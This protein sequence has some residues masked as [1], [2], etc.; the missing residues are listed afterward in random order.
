MKV[1]RILTAVLVCGVL[2]SN[3]VLALEPEKAE[4]EPDGQQEYYFTEELDKPKQEDEA[5]GQMEQANP[6]ST[7]AIEETEELL[8]GAEGEWEQKN[9]R[10]QTY[11]VLQIRWRIC[12]YMGRLGILILAGQEQVIRRYWWIPGYIFW[13]LITTGIRHQKKHWIMNFQYLEDIIPGRLII[14]WYL[15]RAERLRERRFTES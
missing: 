10:L 8:S 6:E 12:L 11:Q 5:A 13:I 4:S 2:F 1:R 14:T 3:T 9:R 7:E 15:A